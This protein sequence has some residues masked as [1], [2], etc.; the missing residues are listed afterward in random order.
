MTMMT[1]ATFRL[2]Q[3]VA[4]LLYEAKIRRVNSSERADELV[5][6]QITIWH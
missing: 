3:V 5:I 6:D 2:V 1:T 4:S